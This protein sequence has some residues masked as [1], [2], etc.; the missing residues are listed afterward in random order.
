MAGPE[1]CRQ[2]FANLTKKYV[3]FVRH[4]KQT[5]NLKTQ[6]P[7]HYDLLHKIG[8]KDKVCLKDVPENLSPSVAV[9]IH[10]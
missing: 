8:D 3:E 10:K 1:K 4:C 5:G 9:Q 2:K 7:V 6:K